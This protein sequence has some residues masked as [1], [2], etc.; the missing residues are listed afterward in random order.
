M[1]IL[2]KQT[3]KI[4]R[5]KKRLSSYNRTSDL[6][7]KRIVDSLYPKPHKSD[8]H[9]NWQVLVHNTIKDK[10][11]LLSLQRNDRLYFYIHCNNP[12]RLPQQHIG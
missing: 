5:V 7:D 6:K 1:P 4:T 8:R 10:Q 2:A 11:N 9:H 3:I 12:L